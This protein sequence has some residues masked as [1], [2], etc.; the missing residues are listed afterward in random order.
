MALGRVNWAAQQTPASL[1][2]LGLFQGNS[3]PL[4]FVFLAAN[5]LRGWEVSP[6]SLSQGQG[7]SALPLDFA[8]QAL[9][10]GV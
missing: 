8:L 9:A 4:G 3:F 2:A 5:E 1:G 10:G 7:G 6:G